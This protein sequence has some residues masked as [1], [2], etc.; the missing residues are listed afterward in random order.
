MK[1]TKHLLAL[2]IA[3]ASSFAVADD[4]FINVGKMRFSDIELQ[5]ANTWGLSAG[6]AVT[7]NWTLEAAFSQFKTDFRGSD[8]DLHSV[9]YR[10]DGLYHFDTS[11]AWRPYLAFGVG[12]QTLDFGADEDRDTLLN[13]G[14]GFKRDLGGSNWQFRA[15]LRNFTSVDNE[16]DELALTLG[17]GYRFGGASSPAPVAA[18]PAPV[19][20]PVKEVDS[21]GDG[22]FDSKDQCPDTPK[23]HKVDE[24]GCSLTL[25]ETVSIELNIT[26]DSAKAVI[27]PEF[28]SEVAK[29][30]EFMGQYANTIVTVEGHTD[31]Q[32]ADAY[33]QKLSQS[34]ADSVKAMLITKYG[35][36][37]DRVNAVGYGE[38]KPVADNATADGREQNRR[39]VG[40]VSSSVTKTE[41]K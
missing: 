34:R 3:A 12:D 37:A 26:F 20:Q 30:A 23:T 28:E 6:Y 24:V 41:T 31:S 35:I 38:S 8:V 4:V 14:G 27:K 9:Q 39:V 1:T 19:P 40:A 7:D 36:A 13:V 29:L 5:N 10:L 11:S 2:T 17:L 16:Y 22:V 33:N 32:G 15:D 25:T 21:D 18:A